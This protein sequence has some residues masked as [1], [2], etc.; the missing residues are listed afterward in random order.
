MLI[1]TI[2]K[3]LAK[4]VLRVSL[5]GILIQTSHSFFMS[6]AFDIHGAAGLVML[7]MVVLIGVLLLFFAGKAISEAWLE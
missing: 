3:K 5:V 1:I 6:D 2:S 7:I 4:P